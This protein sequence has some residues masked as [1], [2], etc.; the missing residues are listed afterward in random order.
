MLVE[1][2][3]AGLGCGIER[4]IVGTN[5]LPVVGAFVERFDVKLRVAGRVPQC[6]HD[7]IEIGL[8]GTAAHGGDGRVGNIDS[9]FCSLQHGS[10]VD[11]AGV[12]R[13][14]VN[15]NGDFIAQGFH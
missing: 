11:A 7:G 10:R 6:F 9:G 15:G 2:R 5:Y 1:A 14:K 12:M 13:M 3:R 8:A 4:Q